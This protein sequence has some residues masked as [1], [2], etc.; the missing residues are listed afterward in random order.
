[1]RVPLYR[2]IIN[3]I[4]EQI[5]NGDLKSGDKV[6]SEKELAEAFDVS[7]ITSKKAL[8]EL[9]QE[10][11][12]ER[13]RGKGSFVSMTLPALNGYTTHQLGDASTANQ[14]QREP[15]IGLILPDFSSSYGLKLLHSIEEQCSHHDIDLM[16]KRTYGDRRVE[17]IAIKSFAE[18]GVD[19][20]IIFPVHGEHYNAELLKLV[21]E[22]FPLVLVD[23]HLK[24]IPAHAVMT[25]NEQAARE[26]TEHLLELGHDNIAFISP[27]VKNT[28]TIEERLSGFHLAFT[29]RGMNVHQDYV[30]ADLYST[31]PTSFHAKNIEKDQAKLRTFIENHPEVSAFV[32]NEYNLALILTEVLQ[33]CGLRVPE[34][35][36]VTCFDSPEDPF[37]EPFFT[38]IEQGEEV[39][40]YK[41]VQLLLE[42]WQNKEL[43][44]QNVTVDYSMII[45][46]STMAR[47]KVEA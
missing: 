35:C 10:N 1:M 3:H 19:G 32:V 36:S 4:I 14:E 5:K 33:E 40:G 9:A 23:R 27:P 12:I 21:L 2:K 16:L 42:Q 15:V 44:I 24:G 6:P 18:K 22:R 34:D 29:D 47:K 41:A 20:L 13:I 31:L 46:Q 17:E 37:K 45:G 8:D 38:H 39:M 30:V 43:P 11:I 28:S 25:H 26:L 7:R